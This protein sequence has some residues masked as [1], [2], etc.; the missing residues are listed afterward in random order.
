MTL[1]KFSKSHR[2]LTSEDFLYLKEG[3]FCLK[4]PQLIVYIKNS[5]LAQPETRIGI[6][7]SKKVGKSY[8]RNRLKRII[9][10]S[11]RLSDVRLLGM[12]VLFVVGAQLYK[13][14]PIEADAETLLKKSLLQIFASLLKKK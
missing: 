13:V 6:S 3:S 2:L 10:E 9:R 4:A 11:F 8:T 1:T 12:D 14:A 7:V 5:R